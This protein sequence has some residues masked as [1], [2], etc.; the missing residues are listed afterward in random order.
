MSIVTGN[1]QAKS[2]T[3]FGHG[4]MVNGNW[5]NSKF[6]IACDKGDDVEFDDG[7]KKYVNKLRVTTK[8]GGADSGVGAKSTGSA[9]SATVAR[10]SG[11]YSRGVFPVPA[12][13][14]SR[15]IIR[16]N[17]V[18]NAVNLTNTLI[19]AKKIPDGHNLEDVIFSWARLFE[20]YSSGD[21]DVEIQKEIEEQFEVK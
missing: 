17:S 21:I 14:G 7:G 8:G 1:V 18:T 5:Y 12:D 2:T 4:I 11:G 20:K 16:Q 10:S 15:S 9:G 6:P 13:D 19:A 3:K